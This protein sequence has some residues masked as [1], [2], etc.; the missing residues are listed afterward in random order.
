MEEIKLD[1]Q[2]RDQIGS[3]RIKSLRR[4]EFV[5]A[6]VYGGENKQ[7]I[8]VKVDRRAYER[9]MRHHQSQNVVF[10]LNI[11]EGN[12]EL[13]HYSAI[14][15]E[16]QHEPVSDG[17]LHIDF[18]CI[19]LDKEIEVKVPV[20]T[21]GE[22]IGVKQDGGSLDHAMWELDIICLPTK[23]PAR[24]EVDITGLKIGDAIHV[25]DIVLP[26]GVRTKHEPESILVSVVPSMKEV[27]APVAGEE[28]AEPEVIGEKKEGKEAAEEKAEEKEEKK[29]ENKPEE[30]S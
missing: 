13:R 21:K 9:I 23:I 19:S 22:A 26:D 25:K 12:K 15:K 2:V 27:E 8:P 7:A 24:I 18:N 3:R 11:M 28:K 30:K 16:E 20:T 1:V 14:V 5:P 17:L 6:I 10:H 4:E 29:A